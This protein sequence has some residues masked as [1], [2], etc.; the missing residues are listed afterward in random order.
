MFGKKEEIR[1]PE[2]LMYAFLNSFNNKEE[3]LN[4]ADKCCNDIIDHLGLDEKYKK[5]II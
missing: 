3:Y 2:P 1:Q 4:F 5:Q